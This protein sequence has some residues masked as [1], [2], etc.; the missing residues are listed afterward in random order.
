MNFPP[1]HQIDRPVTPSLYLKWFMRN[2]EKRFT[3]QAVHGKTKQWVDFD[4]R[5]IQRGYY[6][7]PTEGFQFLLDASEQKMD[8]LIGDANMLLADTGWQ[9][10]EINASENADSYAR[11]TLYVRM[12]YVA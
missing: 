6:G 12:A 10:T 5:S 8:A 7:T 2:L 3:K 4:S 9:V 1:P 11:P